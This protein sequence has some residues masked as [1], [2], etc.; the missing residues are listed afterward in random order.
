MSTWSRYTDAVGEPS[1]EIYPKDWVGDATRP[2]I[3]FC[4]AANNN[5]TEPRTLDGTIANVY[6]LIDKIVEAGYPVISCYLGG[7]LWGNAAGIALVENAVNRMQTAMGAHPTRIGLIGRSMGHLYAMNWAAQHRSET[8]FV[9]ATM[10]VC[11]LNDIHGNATYTAMI[12]AAYGGS[13]SNTTHGPT[14]NP[15]I[16]TEAKYTGLKWQGWVGVD[17]DSTPAPVAQALA[18]RIGPTAEINVVAGGHNRD[19]FANFNYDKILAFI[20]RSTGYPQN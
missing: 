10:G 5:E 1:V 14:Y 4:H 20:Q 13:Y 11:D 17:D 7:N 19:T 3:V 16:N 6:A 8:D 12:D 2:G 15:F 18:S 9:L